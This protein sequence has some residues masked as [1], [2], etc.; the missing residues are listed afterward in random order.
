MKYKTENNSEYWQKGKN[1][2]FDK[3]IKINAFLT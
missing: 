3:V 1:W 2:F